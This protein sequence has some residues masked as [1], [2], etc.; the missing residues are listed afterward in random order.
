ML[1]FV[2][3][4]VTYFNSKDISHVFYWR[5][6]SCFNA[7]KFCVNCLLE[8]PPFPFS[9]VMTPINACQKWKQTKPKKRSIYC[10]Q[11]DTTAIWMAEKFFFFKSNNCLRSLCVAGKPI[12]S[13]FFLYTKVLS[14]AARSTPRGFRVRPAQ[15]RLHHPSGG[16]VR[17]RQVHLHRGQRRREPGVGAD[18]AA[19][20]MWVQ[21]FY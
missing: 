14:L 11:C 13:F 12:K 1:F 5:Y 6:Q 19:S 4:S 7:G 8:L 15:A 9:R 17:C 2:T 20:S 18:R 3:L 21:E 16:Q 10:C